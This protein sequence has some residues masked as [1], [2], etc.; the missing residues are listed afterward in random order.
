MRGSMQAGFGA[1]N[2]VL[3]RRDDDGV[4]HGRVAVSCTRTVKAAKEFDGSPT[5]PGKDV[6]D[7]ARYAI[8][9]ACRPARMG[10]S[11][12]WASSSGRVRT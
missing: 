11:L 2:T 1:M 12:R 7:G 10:M 8:E 5:H 3:S 9:L 4:P 6:L